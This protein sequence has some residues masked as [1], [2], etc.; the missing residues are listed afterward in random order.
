MAVNLI[1]QA[2]SYLTSEVVDRVA[3]LLGE[4]PDRTEK[5]VEA[6]IP[7]LL[8]GLVNTA[9]TPAGAGRLFDM[10]K[11]EPHEVAHVGGLDSILGNLGG[12]LSGGSL[13]SLTQYGMT[14]LK[15]LFGGKLDSVLDVITKVS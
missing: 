2:K 11:Q 3:G 12:L 1:E 15:A 8:A 6:G 4:S 5:A 9:A 14:V 13:S 7:A 10:L